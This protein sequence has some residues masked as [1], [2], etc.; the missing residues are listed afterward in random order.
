MTAK[1]VAVGGF[2]LGA[3]ALGI[4]AILFFSGGQWFARS[5]EAIVFFQ[6]PVAGL[7]AGAPVTFRGARIGSVKSVAIRVAPD[8]VNAR[9]AVIL[10]MNPK[11]VVRENPELAGEEPNFRRLVQAGL[12]AQL[13]VQSLITGQ[14]RVDLEFRPGT[15]TPGA[16]VAEGLPEIPA[17]RSELGQLRNELTNLPLRQLV[18]AG[19]DALAAVEQLSRHLDAELTPLLAST[20]GALDAATRTFQTADSAINRVQTDA[21]ST[22][23]DLDLLLVDAR[24]QL[25]ARGGELSR[26]LISADRATRQI[27]SLASSLNGLADSRSPFRGNLDATVRDLAGAA[28]SLRA[29]AQTVERSPNALLMGRA[30]R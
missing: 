14:L 1:P 6:E 17:I 7:E 30:S 13:A 20:H 8:R 25:G 10:Q 21:T 19:Q 2:V 15:P 24:D 26:T 16:D 9:I 5:T 22:L 23:R 29:F 18:D 3:I 11:Q 28:S 27:E 4:L 12:R